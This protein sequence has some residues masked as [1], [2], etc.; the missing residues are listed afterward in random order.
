M[1]DKIHW[2]FQCTIDK[3]KT[4]QALANCN[5][6]LLETRFKIAVFYYLEKE[7]NSLSVQLP[8]DYLHSRYI[9]AIDN[10]SELEGVAIARKHFNV[11]K[12]ASINYRLL[13]EVSACNDREEEEIK[14]QHYWQHLNEVERND[15]YT[16]TR[17]VRF[18]NMLNMKKL[19]FCIFTEADVELKRNLL[20]NKLFCSSLFE[21]FLEPQ[22]LRYFN[23]KVL[24]VLS[25]EFLILILAMCE[26]KITCAGSYVYKKTLTQEFCLLLRTLYAIN[27]NPTEWD[28]VT[29]SITCIMDHFIN[30]EEI[31]LAKMV[32]KSV[33]N[34]W[35]EKWFSK[36]SAE[37]LVGFLT[38]KSLK[39]G[40]LDLIV[41]SAFS[42]IEARQKLFTEI[43]DE[44]MIKIIQSLIKKDCLYVADKLFDECQAF[45]S[46]KI[47]LAE[48]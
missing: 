35:I 4:A 41:S 19:L 14:C 45:Q 17:F 5:D 8:Q 40:I 1:R 36:L 37:E 18:S 11:S 21:N 15:I 3:T 22:W 27:A 7:I 46:Y 31:K 16:H 20:H 38:G 12:A 6:L 9:E 43:G 29:Y 30:K 48:K 33:E 44:K 2:T 10:I 28:S 47:Q 34:E 26:R 39:Y 32:L 23:T 42:S 13:F 25:E 24:K